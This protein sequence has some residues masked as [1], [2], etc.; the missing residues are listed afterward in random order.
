MCGYTESETLS[1]AADVIAVQEFIISFKF[2]SCNIETLKLQL[3][4]PVGDL[5]II[6][7]C[8]EEY[9]CQ[10]ILVPLNK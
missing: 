4:S 1:A 6:C 5:S 10:E 9:V 2:E 7:F 8:W 3:N